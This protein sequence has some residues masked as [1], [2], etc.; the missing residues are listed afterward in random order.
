MS[1]VVLLYIYNIVLQH[2]YYSYEKYVTVVVHINTMKTTLDF[3]TL[4]KTPID[5]SANHWLI[6]SVRVNVIKANSEE[7]FVW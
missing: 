7:W 3:N 5:I 2:R 1:G 6:S 4:E